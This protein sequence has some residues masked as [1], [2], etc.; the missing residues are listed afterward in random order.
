MNSKEGFYSFP[1]KYLHYLLP[2]KKNG[3][4]IAF[5]RNETG[6]FPYMLLWLRGRAAH[7]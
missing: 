2:F 5:E 7:S 1:L 6:I 3:I 4:I